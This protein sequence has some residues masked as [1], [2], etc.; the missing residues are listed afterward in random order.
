MQ[1]RLHVFGHIHAGRTDTM[2][3]LKGEREVVRWDEGQRCLERAMTRA[4]GLIVGLID[5]RGW[6]DVVKVVA[7]GA[8]AVL[9]DRVWGGASERGGTLMMNTAL[10]F[11]NT[12]KLGNEPQVVDL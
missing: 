12:G 11:E 1:P 4:D 5:P 6:A 7:Y 2:G 8:L 10:M 3:W 9:W